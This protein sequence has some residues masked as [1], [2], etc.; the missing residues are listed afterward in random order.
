MLWVTITMRVAG[1]QVL[2][3]LLDLGGG[4]RVE[5]RAGLV[6]EDHLGLDRDRPSDA[7]ALL[8]AAGEVEGARPGGP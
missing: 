4:D 8:L 6:E 3:Q 5:G 2:H 1:L 7:E